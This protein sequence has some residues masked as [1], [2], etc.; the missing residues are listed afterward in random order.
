MKVLIWLFTYAF[1]CTAAFAAPQGV[2]SFSH[3]LL[4]N[5]Q[6]LL[7]LPLSSDS[8]HIIAL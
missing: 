3:C 6:F 1:S 5:V 2:Y 4:F 8:L 7:L